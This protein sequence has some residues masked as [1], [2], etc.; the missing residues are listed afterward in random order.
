MNTSKT[1]NNLMVE[2]N[3]INWKQVEK[4]VFKLQKRIYQASQRGDV[5]TVRKLQK[6]LMKS[7]S[8]RIIAVRQV[9]Q[10][11]RGKKT[12][13]FDGIK[14]L[15]F[16]QRIK[17]AI[18]LK[19]IRE[20]KPVRRV[21]IPK[22]DKKEK[23]LLGIP[24]MYDRAAQA[25][26]KLALEPEWETKFEAN[27]YGFRPARSA[28]DAIEAIFMGLR[29]KP[30]YILDADISKCFDKINHTT[31]LKKINTYPAMRRIVKSWLSSGVLDNSSVQTSG[32]GVPQGSPLSPLLA[33]IALHGMEET[34]KEL[35]PSD[36]ANYIKVSVI[37]KEKGRISKPILIRYADDFVLMV[38][39]LEILEKCQIHLEKWLGKIGLKLKPE[40]TRVVHS[41]N[42]HNGYKPGFDFLGFNIRQHSVGKHSSKI[43][44]QTIIKPSSKAVQ[45]HYQNLSKTIQKL[46]NANQA[47][48]IK[49]L[50]PK[51]RGWSN[52]F[53][54]VCSRKTFEKL[55][56]LLWFRLQAWANHRHSSKGK[57]WVCDKYW[58]TY[59][60]N[61]WTFQTLDGL[62]LADHQDTKIKRHI[63]IK[64]M[65]SPFDGRLIYWNQR[66]KKH[67]LMSNS[68]SK[69][70]SRQNG[71][72]AY[73]NLTFREGDVMEI[74]HVTPKNEGGKDTYKNL[75]LLHRHC[76][77]YVHGTRVKGLYTEEPDEGKS[78]M[79]GFE[80]EFKW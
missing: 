79:S 33:N 49:T 44:F 61:N 63:K 22:A 26:A 73:C 65:S 17:L 67:P 47:D 68:K 21:L 10:L 53:R 14:S 54:S 60:G 20:G 75:E 2:W 13:G 76:H 40:K 5:E 74:H 42:C 69:L 51:I 1:Q 78:F 34:I 62:R 64:D 35:Y 57:K 23:R 4:A 8:A 30:K 77:D 31:L 80:D 16:K 24:T 41:L 46:Q 45:K 32:E 18:E 19:T 70:W 27:S 37:G 6:M 11:N 50:N 28:H 39:D 36:K 7:W 59:K 3:T 43:G 72:C 12:A 25:L 29:G 38:E 55:D 52:Y 15:N 58:G 48:L 56:N 9:S 66:M 71:R